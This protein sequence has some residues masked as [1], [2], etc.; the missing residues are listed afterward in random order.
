LYRVLAQGN[1]HPVLAATAGFDVAVA[2]GRWLR[3]AKNR[4]ASDRVA[5]ARVLTSDPEHWVRLVELTLGSFGAI[6][7]SDPAAF[8]FEQS[9]LAA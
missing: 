5:S 8:G 1:H 7:A 9:I 4:P 6:S 2:I 3:F